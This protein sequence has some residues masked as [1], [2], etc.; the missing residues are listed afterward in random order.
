MKEPLT[1]EYT[2]PKCGRSLGRSF[3]RCE[4]SCYNCGTWYVIRQGKIV[5]TTA[6]PFKDVEVR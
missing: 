2:C 5:Q 4:L 3:L 6:L 1:Q